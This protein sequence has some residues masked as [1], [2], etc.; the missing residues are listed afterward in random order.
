MIRD[1]SKQVEELFR[2][3]RHVT[4]RKRWSARTLW[5]ATVRP[6][7][8]KLRAAIVAVIGDGNAQAFAKWCARHR[9]VTVGN[10]TLT[11]D[12]SQLQQA[13]RYYIAHS[14]DRP[15]KPLTLH[16]DGTPKPPRPPGG[17]TPLPASLWHLEPEEAEIQ[18]IARAAQQQGKTRSDM[19]A[20]MAEYSRDQE[21]KAA[22]LASDP[23]PGEVWCGP[24]LDRADAE[25]AAEFIRKCGLGCGSTVV[26]I[27]SEYYARSIGVEN[28]ARIADGLRRMHRLNARVG[29]HS[30]AP[31][32]A[33]LVQQSLSRA[34]EWRELRQVKGKPIHPEK[35]L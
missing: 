29:L 10:F 9:G 30:E 3:I 27:S 24:Y 14:R 31:G 21:A 11:G 2:Q 25:R 13:W 28:A 18:K 33:E 20:R 22:K 1:G 5:Q 17:P 12:Y 26:E 19:Q 23:A 6:G 35:A 15:D 16:G 4:G 8:P 32:H 7:R 34:A